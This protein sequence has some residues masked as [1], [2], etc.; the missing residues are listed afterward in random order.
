MILKRKYRYV[1]VLASGDID[2]ASAGN[3]IGA[4]LMRFMGE[5]EYSEANPRIVA[6]YTPRLFVIKVNRGFEDRLVLSLSFVK[7][8]QGRAIGFSTLKTSGTIKSLL[9][10]AQKMRD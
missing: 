7:H 9:L 1:L 5:L 3:S 10:Y 6:Q 2:A 8:V 4:E